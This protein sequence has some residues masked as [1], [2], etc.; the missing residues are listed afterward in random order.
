MLRVGRQLERPAGVVGRQVRDQEKRLALPLHVVVDREPVYV[1]VWHV[2]SLLA[3]S[4]VDYRAGTA[5]ASTMTQADGSF[6][7]MSEP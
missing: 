2:R 5:R 7:V 6:D 3:L 1:D 4:A